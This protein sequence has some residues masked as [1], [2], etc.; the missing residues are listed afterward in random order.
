MLALRFVL[1]KRN[2]DK[3]MQ[4]EEEGIRKG[5]AKPPFDLHT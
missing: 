1:S 4:R 5:G 3:R 2:E